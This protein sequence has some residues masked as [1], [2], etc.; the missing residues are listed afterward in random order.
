LLL[1]VLL[2]LDARRT[3]SRSVSS[4]CMRLSRRWYSYRTCT[5]T[6]HSTA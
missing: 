4:C 6:Q 5:P 2:R 1:S 3:S